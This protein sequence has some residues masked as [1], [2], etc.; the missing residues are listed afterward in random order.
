MLHYKNRLAENNTQLV[1][2]TEN[3]D[4]VVQYLKDKGILSDEEEERVLKG[5]GG[6][7]AEDE[8]GVS[9]QYYLRE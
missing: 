6:G 3:L 1:Y 2:L 7:G 4:E 5:G 9:S 8:D